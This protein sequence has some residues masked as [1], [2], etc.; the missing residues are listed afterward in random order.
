MASPLTLEAFGEVLQSPVAAEEFSAATDRPLVVVDVDQAIPRADR[1]AWAPVLAGLPCVVVARARHREVLDE[2]TA[3]L[4]DV[5][6]VDDGAHSEPLRRPAVGAEA[7]GG[8]LDLLTASVR[9]HP[10]AAVTL[11]LL[12]RGGDGR[13]IEEG[14]VAESTAYSMLQGSPEFVTWLAARTKRLRPHDGGDVVLVERQGSVLRVTLNRPARHNAFTSSIRDQLVDALTLADADSTIDRVVLDG[15]GPSFCSG[16]DLDEFG[17]LPDPATGHVVRLT[18]SPARLLARLAPRVFV[19]LH[20]SCMGAG[21]ELPAFAG[22][23]TA[24]PDTRMALPELSLG[25]IPGAG[26]TVSL[27]RRIGRHRTAFLALSGSIVD[28]RVAL[29]WGLVDDVRPGPG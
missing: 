17:A 4:F 22:H 29:A 3:A 1:T 18:R 8:A 21:I 6:V 7:G 27:P 26:G 15:A 24:D 9:R 16:G 13:S 2:E 19:Q 25:L 10:L 23:V 12:L 5:V 20:G 14:L 28:A 11:A